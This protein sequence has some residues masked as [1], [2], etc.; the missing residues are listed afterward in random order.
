MIEN[1]TLESMIG[2]ATNGSNIQMATRSQS[3]GKRP[4]G[5]LTEAEEALTNSILLPQS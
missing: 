1:T 3:I 2:G 4:S 5:A